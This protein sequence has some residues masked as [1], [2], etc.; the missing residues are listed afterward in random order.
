MPL[1]CAL[2]NFTGALAHHYKAQHNLTCTKCKKAF[3]GWRVLHQHFPTCWMSPLKRDDPLTAVT[4]EG[5]PL[6]YKKMAST[7]EP[8]IVWYIGWCPLS[9]FHVAPFTVNGYTYK[10]VEHFYQAEK[11]L[12]FQDF[13][14]YN[15]ILL[16]WSPRSVKELGLQ[17]KNY[18]EKEWLD[19]C[20]V[21][22]EVAVKE[23]VK[24]NE[25]VKQALLATGAA[26]L[27][28]ATP[29][30]RFWGIGLSVDEPDLLKLEAWGEN[31]LGKLLM[32]IR[33]ELTEC[34]A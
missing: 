25:F 3:D 7:G 13:D 33:Q 16:T 29:H 2:C 32:K 18:S 21:V 27:G 15:K 9:N 34:P 14:T 12:F 6:F 31:R 1:K 10:T 4:S 30:D 5:K 24:Q 28:E 20:D 23:K 17:I 26:K 11:A 19:I 22:M 8:L